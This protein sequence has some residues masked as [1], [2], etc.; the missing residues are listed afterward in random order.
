MLQPQLSDLR[1]VYERQFLG[2]TLT[3]VSLEELV[4][5]RERLIKDI[6]RSLTDEQK[7]FLVSFKRGEPDWGLL[8]T[9]GIEHLPAVQWKLQ[10]IKRMPKAKHQAALSKLE[11]VLYG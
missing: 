3:P 8:G 1:A 11:I 4:V 5:V 9:N 6:H 2:M 10:N 7:Q